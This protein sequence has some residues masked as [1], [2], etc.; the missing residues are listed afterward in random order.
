MRPQAMDKEIGCKI[1]SDIADEQRYDTGGLR[2]TPL[3]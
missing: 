3:I 1:E 2:A